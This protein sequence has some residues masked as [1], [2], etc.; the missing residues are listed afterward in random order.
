MRTLLETARR[1]AESDATI[2]I[3]GESG[4]GKNVT[5]AAIHRWS[6]HADRPFVTITCATLADQL[7]ESELFGHVR[8]AFTG[9]WREKPGRLETAEGGTAFLDEI[10]ELPSE[11]QAKL[12]RFLEERSFERVGGTETITVK[13]RIVA[14]TSR[15]LSDEVRAGRFR[16]DLFYRLNVVALDLP[17][18]RE[19]RE[20]VRALTDHV[21][22]TLAVRHRRPDLTLAPAAR[23]AIEKYPW[24][25]NVRELLN[26]LERAVVVGRGD[27]VEAD[28]LPERVLAPASALPPTGL[29]GVDGSLADVERVHVQ[30]VLAESPTLEEAAERLGI[31]PTTLWRKRKRW[32][33]D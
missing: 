27:V 18:L 24:P 4:A 33:L 11:V 26:A 17:P 12:L 8:G 29:A 13:T 10:G 22:A 28:D 31:N 23:R 14:A 25:G 19:R 16:E 7:V 21:L 9:A 30:R 2:L 3:T 6:A 5:A 1:A 15:N 32:G 20:D